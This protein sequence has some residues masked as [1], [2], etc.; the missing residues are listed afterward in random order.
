MAC[1]CHVQRFERYQVEIRKVIALGEADIA[2]R[3][4]RYM[5]QLAYIIAATQ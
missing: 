2:Y 4:A 1:P 3:M 5:S